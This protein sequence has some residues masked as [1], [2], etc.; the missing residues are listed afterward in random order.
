MNGD[1]LLQGEIKAIPILKISRT[2][3]P[4][5][6]KLNW[7]KTFLGE[8]KVFTNKD[9]SLLKKEIIDF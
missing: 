5:S 8:G 6:T 2:P 9:H 4:I 1:A 3:G 7:H